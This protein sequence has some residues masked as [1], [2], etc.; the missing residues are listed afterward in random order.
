MWL[1]DSQIAYVNHDFY[2]G[3]LSLL[4]PRDPFEL[5]E[6]LL[7]YDMDSEEELDELFGEDV[8]GSDLDYGEEIVNEKGD[9]YDLVCEGFIVDDDEFSDTDSYESNDADAQEKRR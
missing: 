4:N 6:E 8:E 1:C 3:A 9:D 2:K 5:D 7:N